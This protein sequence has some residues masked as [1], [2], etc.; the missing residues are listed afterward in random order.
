MREDQHDKRVRHIMTPAE[1][2]DYLSKMP[3]A[4]CGKIEQCFCTRKDRK[5]LERHV[6]RREG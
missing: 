5:R 1:I 2:K 6:E 4:Y 3:C